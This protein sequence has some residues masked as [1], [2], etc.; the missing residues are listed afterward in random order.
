MQ[1][2]EDWRTAMTHIGVGD[3]KAEEVIQAMFRDEEGNAVMNGSTGGA[4][5]ELLQLISVMNRAENGEFELD[6]L[7]LSGHHYKG[8][9]YL[10]GEKGDHE[11]D[12]NDK[13]N[14]G[15]IESLAGVFGKASAGVDNMMFSACNT[16][17]LGMTDSEGNEQTTNQWMQGMFPNIQSSSYWDGIAPGPDMAAFFSGEYMLDTAK[18][19]AGQTGALNDAKF[20][21][22]SKG[23]NLRSELN[24]DG[25]LEQFDTKAKGSSYVYNDY[26]GLRNSGGEAYHKRT[27]LMDYIYDGPETKP[28]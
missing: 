28:E 25:Q 23:T 3:E 21:K 11:Y 8:T 6:A 9:D 15:D 24:A 22:T 18:E 19:S 16:N 4:S 10:F 26:K 13:L 14:M 20:R 7:V 2:S 17:D 5:N 27:D 12:M 1:V